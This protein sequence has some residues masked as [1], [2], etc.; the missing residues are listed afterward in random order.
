MSSTSTFRRSIAK[1]VDF[2]VFFL[3]VIT[4][5]SEN[6]NPLSEI[7]IKIMCIS[8]IKVVRWE[9]Q[10]TIVIRHGGV[11][12][13]LSPP[14]FSPETFQFQWICQINGPIIERYLLVYA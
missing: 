13:F 10:L 8:V 3:G 9:R 5:R 2:P 1:H 4:I 7:V 14:H 11:A 6:H 12:P